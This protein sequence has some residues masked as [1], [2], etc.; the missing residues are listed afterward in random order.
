MK[1]NKSPLILI[2]A[3]FSLPAITD[4]TIGVSITNAAGAVIAA[5]NPA[6]TA[7]I[8]GLG[9]LGTAL[10]AAALAAL[11]PRPPTV[12][13]I[14]Q[15]SPTRGGKYYYS[16]HRGK[17]QTISFAR[18]GGSSSELSEKFNEIFLEIEDTSMDTCFQRLICEI[19][20]GPEDNRMGESYQL[21]AAIEIAMAFRLS[22]RAMAVAQR[23]A[24]GKRV[25]KAAGDVGVCASTYKQCRWTGL[26]M[27]Q[28]IQQF[29]VK[30]N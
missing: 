12:T 7:G 11:K 1:F 2:C 21:I 3:I 20:A 9:L 19:M 5:A 14:R 15:P 30:Y 18:T 24:T 16:R 4:A 25:G 27:Q 28:A 17:R 29:Q 26:E 8:V 23:I 6:Q 13:V 22:P 10:G